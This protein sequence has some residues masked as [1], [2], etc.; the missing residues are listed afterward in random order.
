[1]FPEVVHG[2]FQWS[3]L[4]LPKQSNSSAG[5]LLLD[6]L[7]NIPITLSHQQQAQNLFLVCDLFPL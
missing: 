2:K 7:T 4:M 3:S 6:S 1:M 5:L